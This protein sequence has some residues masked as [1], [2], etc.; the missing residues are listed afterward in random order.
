MPGFVKFFRALLGWILFCSVTINAA[1][2]QTSP[3]IAAAEQAVADANEKLKAARIAQAE[4]DIAAADEL[5]L[6]AKAAREYL[7]SAQAP[8]APSQAV[9]AG[10]TSDAKLTDAGEKSPDTSK[11]AASTGSDD[12]QEFGGIK[13]GVGMS[14]TIDLGESQR[15]VEAEI[16]DGLVRA[17]KTDNSKARI[18]LES[19]YFFTPSY[20]LFGLDEDEWGIGPFLAVRPGSDDVIDAIAFGGMIGFRYAKDSKSSFNIGMGLVIDPSVQILGKGL[21]LDRPLPG[22]ETEIRFRQT[23]QKGML[24]MVSFSF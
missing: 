22:N 17:V 5:A 10:A 14:V 16:V 2:A 24:L 7:A 4:R 1:Q 15:V 6:K 20:S 13:F 23:S 9:S 8:A 11:S 3:E 21:E 18:M 12:T 19:H